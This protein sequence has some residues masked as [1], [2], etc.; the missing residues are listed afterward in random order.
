MSTN[1]SKKKRD[2]LLDKIKQI[3]AFIAAAPQDENTGNLLSYLSEL[4]KDVN[5]KKYGL[6]FEE[7]REKIDEVLDTHTPVLTEDADLFIDHGGQMNFLLEGDNLA[8]LKLLEKTH[9]GN[10]DLIFIDPPYNTRNGDFGYDDS[11][12]DLTDTFRHSKWVS[13][14]SERLLVARRLLKND[15]VIFIAIDDNEQAALKLLCDQLFGEENFL[16]SIIW[17]HSIQPKG[18]SGTFSV[19]HNYILCYQKTAQFVLNS[20]PRTDEDN[21]AYA[22][23]DNDP[24]GRWRSGDVRNALYRPNLIY[25]IISPSGNVIKPCANG[26]RWSKETV[27]EKI[28]SGEIIFSKDETRIIRKIYLDTLEGRTPETIWFGKDV[29]TTRSAMS[30]IKEIFGSSA[31]GTPKPTSLIERTLRLI[32]RTDATVLDFF[33]GSGT[34]GHAVMKLNAEDGGTR[35]FILCTN[36]E[37]G[38]CRDVT[39]E[40]IRRVIDKEDYAASLKYYKV[41][42]VPI[43]DRMYYEYADELLRHIRELVELE[44]GINFTGNEEIAIVLT[45]EELE[46]FLDDEG[47]CKRC[48]KLYMGHDVLLDAQQAQALQEY[49][50]AVNVIP[51]YYYKELEG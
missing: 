51:D 49:N 46:I 1:I 4:E 32:S 48:R 11:R 37:N 45:D 24:R 42:Y 16:A 26:W 23:P 15:G 40:R 8:A 20:L 30:E 19:H 36:N 33:A 39:Y 17:Q 18:Y 29:G 47:I 10:I 22:N 7:H 35:R 2:D 3:R 9:R 21:K 44:N 41:G 5:G 25:D 27:E 38:I 34:T 43:S 13:F 12:V 6:V 28:K 31:F 14:M 50:I